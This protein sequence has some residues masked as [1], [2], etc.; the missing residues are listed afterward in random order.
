MANSSVSNPANALKFRTLISYRPNLRSVGPA[1]F[2]HEPAVGIGTHHV[3]I[4]ASSEVLRV[5]RAHF[6]IHG[7]CRGPVDQVMAVARAFWKRSAIARVQYSLAVIFDE[8]Q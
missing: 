6:D 3:D 1:V 4:G 5:P 7:H 8:H 2:M